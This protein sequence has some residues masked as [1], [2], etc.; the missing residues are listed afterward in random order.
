MSRLDVLKK[1]LENKQAQFDR[2]LQAH[3]DCVK[4]ANGQPLNDKRNGQATLSKWERQNESLRS[5]NVSIEKTKEAI[6]REES[7]VARVESVNLP[8]P[9]K[10][11]IESGS[12]TQW[13]K[14]PT[15]FFVNGVDKAR[16][17]LLDNGGIAH[18]FLTSIPSQEQYAIFRDVFNGLRRD[19]AN[20]A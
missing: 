7:K 12:L 19:L 15:Y 8:D 20:P 16:I 13:R 4:Q 2:K 6:D 18:K 9:I 5:L 1:S 11:L 14:H 10:K 3:M 17:V